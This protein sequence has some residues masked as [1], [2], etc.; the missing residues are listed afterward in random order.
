MRAYTSQEFEHVSTEVCLTVHPSKH[1]AFDRFRRRMLNRI[2]TGSDTLSRLS[3]A[4]MPSVSPTLIL[5]IAS[6]R[7]IREA[8]ADRITWSRWTEGGVGEP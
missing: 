7:H 8:Q 3:F 4:K 6:C 2:T 5:N 1:R